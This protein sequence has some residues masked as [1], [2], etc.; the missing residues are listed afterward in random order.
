M[1]ITYVVQWIKSMCELHFPVVV[2]RG[3]TLKSPSVFELHFAVAVQLDN[4]VIV[5]NG[6]ISKMEELKVGLY[7]VSI[8][9]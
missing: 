8:K 3:Y 6:I 4:L 7:S 9:H 2:L 1:D 5:V